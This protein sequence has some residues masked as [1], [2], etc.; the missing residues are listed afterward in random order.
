MINN[1]HF[2]LAYTG[3]L[4]YVA[5]YYVMKCVS[6]WCATIINCK[7]STIAKIVFVGYIHLV[8]F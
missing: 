3:S 2:S 5:Y 8:W 4:Q 7:I 6:C 1:Y